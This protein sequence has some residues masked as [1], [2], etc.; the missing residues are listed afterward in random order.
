[1]LAILLEEHSQV[2]PLEGDQ[3]ILPWL[4]PRDQIPLLP[5]KTRNDHGDSASCMKLYLR[6]VTER[7]VEGYRYER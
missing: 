3:H 1:M 2:S 7:G 4:S 5:K 6:L